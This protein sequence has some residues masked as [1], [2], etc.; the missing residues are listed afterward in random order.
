M[1]SNQKTSYGLCIR[2][3]N[4]ILESRS[5]EIQY[6][7]NPVELVLQ[8]Q[9]YKQQSTSFHNPR[10][11][12]MLHA[13]VTNLYIRLTFQNSSMVDFREAYLNLLNIFFHSWLVVGT[14]EN[15]LIC[16]TCEIPFSSATWN[17]ACIP[18]WWTS[19]SLQVTPAF[20]D[21]RPDCSMDV[22]ILCAPPLI[23][24]LVC[25]EWSQKS[26]YLFVLDCRTV[27]VSS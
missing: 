22:Y 10:N 24:R 18:A 6:E 5:L 16:F 23:T 12:N 17:M 8:V 11:G 25:G 19:N 4:T 21:S 15:H 1:I 7:T 9:K 14:C 26:A 13:N 20:T 27:T 2:Y 3:L